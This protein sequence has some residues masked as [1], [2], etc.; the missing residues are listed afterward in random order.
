MKESSSSSPRAVAPA[1]A[2]RYAARAD[3]GESAMFWAMS[4]RRK[5]SSGRPGA[6][7]ASS[8]AARLSATLAS[9]ARS[10]TLRRVEA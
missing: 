2:R 7:G 3:S 5:S 6:A 8:A 4:P 9:S 1:C 10:R